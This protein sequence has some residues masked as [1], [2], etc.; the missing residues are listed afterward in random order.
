MKTP[1]R[2]EDDIMAALAFDPSAVLIRTSGSLI[3]PHF[4]SSLYSELKAEH[5]VAGASATAASVDR[6]VFPFCSQAAS[7]AP[8]IVKKM[9]FFNLIL[10]LVYV[11]VG[12]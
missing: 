4:L 11:R 5:G 7:E 10:R 1:P 8:R 9:K 2:S 12:N 6:W 3:E